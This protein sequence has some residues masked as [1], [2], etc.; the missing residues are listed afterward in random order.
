MHYSS[1]IAGAKAGQ[2]NE[3]FSSILSIL[4]RIRSIFG[5]QR[6][7]TYSSIGPAKDWNLWQSIFSFG[8][9]SKIHVTEK[10]ALGIPGYFRAVNIAAEQIGSLSRGVYRETEPGVIEEAA[11]HPLYRLIKYRPSALYNSFDFFEVIVRRLYT[12]GNVFIQQLWDSRGAL[13]ELRLRDNLE[14]ISERNGQL[15][16]KFYGDT[17][18]YPGTDILH[19]KAY[20]LDGI[21]GLSPLVLLQEALGKT[22]AEIEFTS[23]FF[24]NGAHPSGALE[25][26]QKL[27]ADQQ[28]AMMDSFNEKYGGPDNVGRVVLLQGGVKFKAISMDMDKAQITQS[29]ALSLQDIANITGVP[30]DLLNSGDKTSTYAS[31]EQRNLQF[32]QYTLRTICKKI[33]VEFNTKIFSS[34]EIGKV[35]FRFNLDALLRGDTAARTAYYTAGIAGRWLN[36]NEV[37]ALETMNPYEGGDKYENPNTTSPKTQANEQGEGETDNSDSSEG[38]ASGG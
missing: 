7:A 14:E 28:R 12:R 23:S 19:I 21:I 16:Y 15:F 11:T 29:R 4:T 32:V 17:Q 20:S 1:A 6:R 5:I 25:T 34:R 8:G 26:D 33:E 2:P 18:R 10:R 30:L 31:A 13:T 27:T 37:R 38:E 24:G 36:P 22:I 3:N 9:K 35:F